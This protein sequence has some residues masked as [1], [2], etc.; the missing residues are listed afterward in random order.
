[1]PHEG[2]TDIFCRHVP[3]RTFFDEDR[4]HHDRPVC[5][6]G[7][8]REAGVQSIRIGWS[9]REESFEAGVEAAQRALDS[10]TISPNDIILLF[11]TSFHDPIALRNGITSILGTE[12]S[13]IGGLSVGCFDNTNLGYGG[14]Q[15]GLIIFSPGETRAEIFSVTDLHPGRVESVGRELGEQIKAANFAE[16]PILFLFYDSF[17]RSSGRMELNMGTLLLKGLG[18]SLGGLPATLYGAGLLGDMRGQPSCQWRGETVIDKAAF[19]LAFSGGGLKIDH[20]LFYG[21]V[22]ASDYHL[23]TKSEGSTILE[24]DN[25]PAI[26]VVCE[27]VGPGLDPDDFSFNIT[28]GMNVG[29]QWADYHPDHYINRLCLKADT[30][31]GGIV[32]C[33]PE[34]QEGC[35]IQLMHRLIEFDKIQEGVET[36]FSSIAERKPLFAFY[37][38]CAGRAGAYSGNDREDVVEIQQAIGN[39]IP[40]FGIYGGS[41]IGSTTRG[42]EYMDWTGVL[43]LWSL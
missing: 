5:A 12:A 41:E 17:D 28:L 18:D 31:R 15:T 14:P 6:P 10:G 24:I 3:R 13:L 22:P 1:M 19:V 27:I 11:S 37:I 40:M 32:M 7:K 4:C 26:D 29:D 42:P 30:K 39:R 38:N 23:I 33:G 16:P 9:E 20:V 43:C 34:L 8:N 2:V 35:Q 36:L 21:C 25:R